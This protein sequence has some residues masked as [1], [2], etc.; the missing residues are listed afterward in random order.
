MWFHRFI[1]EKI[2]SLAKQ[3]PAIV[4]TGARQTGK[5]TLLKKL[6]PQHHFVSLD[7][8]SLAE[9]AEKDPQTFLKQHPTPIIIDEIQYAPKLFRYLKSWI[10]EHRKSYGQ[11]I[12]TGSQKFVL[13]KNLSE[14]L[15]GRCA[16]LELETLAAQEILA[17]KPK[18]NLL[19]LMVRGGF[20]ELHARPEL[21]P[22]TYYA[23][24]VA[25]YLERDVRTLLN[26]V[27]LRDFERFLR[28]CAL[29]SGQMLN[30]ADLARDVGISPTTANDWISVLCASNQI[31]LLEPWFS[32]K[33]K[34]LVKSP[35]LYIADVGILCFLL[36]ITSVEQL[37]KSPMVG[38]IW[39]TY[40]FS[41]LRK[42]A[43][44]QHGKW[45]LWYWRD[46]RGLEVDF[47]KHQGGHFGL[48]ECKFSEVPNNRD[49]Q[50]LHKVSHILGEKYVDT[51]EI[52]CRSQSTW[53]LD[54]DVMVRA[55]V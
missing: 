53:P 10:D 43:F 41:E 26:V 49:A 8:P 36:E 39:E 55:L 33:T 32:N 34:T 3:Y 40:V 23:S 15:A 21:D 27:Q 35:K 22:Y 9:M 30:K 54:N 47:L 38:A 42:R 31:F 28:I 46:N 37:Q 6:F 11:F 52:Y 19:D 24:Y 7:L 14:S 18:K 13:M 12:L 48:I 50:N 20:P 29:R 51:K 25:T 4:L 16:I 2:L 1:S 45:N 17:V 5:T 44:F